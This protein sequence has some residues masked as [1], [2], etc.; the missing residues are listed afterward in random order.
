[1][2]EYK[3]KAL[4][5]TDAID[6]SGRRSIPLGLAITP[7]RSGRPIFIEG[8]HKS[9]AYYARKRFQQLLHRKVDVLAQSVNGAKGYVFA[10]HVD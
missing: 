6:L 4:E 9:S 1:M 10:V 3:V 8:M 5:S 2:R 7:L